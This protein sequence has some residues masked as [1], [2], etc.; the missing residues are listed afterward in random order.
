VVTTAAQ[1]W[2]FQ[3]ESRAMTGG[4]VISAATTSSVTTATTLR[5]TGLAP[6]SKSHHHGSR[7]VL[8][9]RLTVTASISAGGFVFG[10]R[11]PG[12]PTMPLLQYCRLQQP[13]KG[14]QVHQVAHHPTGAT[15]S[16]SLLWPP[17]SS[18]RH[19][20]PTAIAVF[21]IDSHLVQHIFAD[22]GWNHLAV[23]SGR[24]CAVDGA[25]FAVLHRR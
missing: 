23:L 10:T 13:N 11:T 18:A 9:P 25:L 17:C 21:G 8:P 5:M 6:S 19:G 3:V 15:K 4:L 12:T 24:R 2:D 16:W 1:A 14:W 22:D 20:A 7:D